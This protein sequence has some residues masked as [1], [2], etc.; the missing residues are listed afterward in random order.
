MRRLGSLKKY[1]LETSSVFLIISIRE[2]INGVRAK[3]FQ[4]ENRTNFYFLDQQVKI[5]NI[6]YNFTFFC[7]K[8]TL[9]IFIVVERHKMS[10]PIFFCNKIIEIREKMTDRQ[11]RAL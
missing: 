8:K 7:F 2:E 3:H 6:N 9:F 5:I 4:E 11:V 1:D 10:L